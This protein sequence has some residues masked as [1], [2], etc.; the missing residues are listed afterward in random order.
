[1]NNE[2]WVVKT[3]NGTVWGRILRVIIDSASR[4]IVSVD[5]ILS[6]QDRFVRVPWK[7][8]EVENDDLILVIAEEEVVKLE[9]PSGAALPATMTLEDSTA[10]TV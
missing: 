1:M 4:Q 10:C 6:A 8:M 9:C 7:S 3:R 2:P 5:V